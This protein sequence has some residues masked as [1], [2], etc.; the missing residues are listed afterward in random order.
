MRFI[1]ATKES[2]CGSLGKPDILF[3]LLLLLDL[4]PLHVHAMPCLSSLF[5]I[6][7]PI[8]LFLYIYTYIYIY[9][10]RVA[11]VISFSVQCIAL[12]CRLMHCRSSLYMWS[13]CLG[14]PVKFL[15]A[16]SMP[17]S[18]SIVF[19]SALDLT[20]SILCLSLLL[21]DCRSSERRVLY[22]YV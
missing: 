13:L 9:T 6:Q 12:A 2:H 16:A 17:T 21:E 5:D 11:P 4:L 7:S 10:V 22:L 1:T 3:L 18:P 15:R 8:Y 14:L 19:L 20:I